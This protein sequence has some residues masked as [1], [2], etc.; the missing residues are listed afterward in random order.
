MAH[1]I[2]IVAEDDADSRLD[3]WFKRHR[4]EYNHSLLQKMLRKKDIRVNRKR[5][6]TDTRLEEGDE[7]FVLDIKPSTDEPR[8]VN[9][10]QPVAGHQIEDF[11]SWIIFENK[12]YLAINK[13]QGL[14]SQGG[15]GITVSVDDIIRTISPRYKLVHRLDKDTSGVLVIAKKTTAASAF[16]RILQSGGVDKTYIALVSGLPELKEGEI[17]LPLLKKGQPE[18]MTV[19]DKGKYALSEYRI[20]QNLGGAMSILELKPITGRTHQLRVHCAAIGHP[21]IGDGKYG[22]TKAFTDGFSNKLHLHARSISIP[23]LDIEAEAPLP[24]AFKELL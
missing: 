12:D 24:S 7:I 16:S 11:N 23:E 19:D 20:L 9:A 1:K 2:H 14:A 22:G 17:N 5:A 10:P 6:Q 15:R 4:P 8:K 13:P 3:R 18:K 21:I